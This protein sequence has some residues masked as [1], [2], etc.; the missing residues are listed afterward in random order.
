MAPEWQAVCVGVV[1]PF[2][3]D[4]TER[5]PAASGG[6]R[7]RCAIGDVDCRGCTEGN[8]FDISEEIEGILRND[9]RII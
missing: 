1:D 3:P 2:E 6:Y 9:G 8:K 7:P 4:Y 5:D